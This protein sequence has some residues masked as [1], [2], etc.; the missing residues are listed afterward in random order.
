MEGTGC[1]SSAKIKTADLQKMLTAMKS[2]PSASNAQPWEVVVIE[3][4]KGKQNIQKIFLDQQFRP[5]TDEQR[6]SNSWITKAPMILVMAIDTMRANA[7]FG[8]L[9]AERFALVDLGGAGQN[10]LLCGKE[11]G[12]SGTFVRNFDIDMVSNML[13][14]PGHVKPVYLIALGYSQEPPAKR[15][16]LELK[17]FVHRELW[18]NYP[19]WD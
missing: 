15:P 7:K 5:L 13:Q 17:D 12:I 3:S 1:Y 8:R 9:G 11:L 2:A 4:G 10:L 16:M 14:L 6:S 19:Q 18:G